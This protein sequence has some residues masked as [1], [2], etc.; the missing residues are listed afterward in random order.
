MSNNPLVTI[1]IPTLNRELVMGICLE[2][3]K[4]QTYKNIEVNIIDGGSKDKTLEI[5]RSFG[6]EK[7]QICKDALLRARFEGVKLAEGE[8]VVLLDDDQI[9][10][11]DTIERAVAAMENLDML[12]LGE[13]VYKNETFIENLFHYDRKL[14]HLVKDFDPNTGVM[15]PRFYR[16]EILEKA[17]KN[18]PEDVL[19]NVGGQDHAIIYWEAWQLS[20]KVILLDDAVKHIEPGDLKTIVKKFYRWGFTS[21]GA[22]ANRYTEL[23]SKKENFR[24]GLFRAGLFKESIAS[25]LLLIIKGVPYKIGHLIGK[26]K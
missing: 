12:V 8:F 18:I 7:I 10:E 22:K 15:L 5:A 6:I 16:K 23:F 25:I 11:K 13:D 17:F 2:A 3:I 14:V 26:L 20:K 21:V 19:N 24:K 1:S 9:L 4:N